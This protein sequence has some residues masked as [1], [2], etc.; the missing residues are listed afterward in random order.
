MQGTDLRKLISTPSGVL[1]AS[2]WYVLTCFIGGIIFGL[3]LW[4]NAESFFVFSAG[5][6]IYPILTIICGVVCI[7]T[8]SV[9][10]RLARE[11]YSRIYPL[12]S[13]GPEVTGN[14]T[15]KIFFVF[16]SIIPIMFLLLPFSYTDPISLALTITTLIVY[17]TLLK[18]TSKNTILLGQLVFG[19]MIFSFIMNEILYSIATG[20]ILLLW[21]AF[22][23]GWIIAFMVKSLGSSYKFPPKT[24]QDSFGINDAKFI[25]RMYENRN[26]Q[27]NCPAFSRDDLWDLLDRF[28]K[29]IS[30][31]SHF[32]TNR[33]VWLIHVFY[34]P[35]EVNLNL[36]TYMAKFKKEVKRLDGVYNFLTVLAALFP[37][38]LMFILPWRT[39]PDLNSPDDEAFEHASK[40]ILRAQRRARLELT[41]KG[42]IVGLTYQNGH[43][44]FSSD[45]GESY[46]FSLPEVFFEDIWDLEQIIERDERLETTGLIY[47]QG[48]FA[49]KLILISNLEE[50]YENR[51]KIVQLKVIGKLGEKNLVS[52]LQQ[53]ESSKLEFK[54]S[55]WRN[56]HNNLPIDSQTKKNPK[57]EDAIIKTI[58]G[59][60]NSEGGTLL[61]GVSDTKSP[62]GRSLVTGIEHDYVW[63]KKNNQNEDGFGQ[64]IENIVRD[65][66]TSSLTPL[67][68]HISKSFHTIQG[69]TICR[70]DVIPAPTKGHGYAV[71]AKISTEKDMR[72]FIRSG[73]TTTMQSPE[74]QMNYIFGHFLGEED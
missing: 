27:K 25:L 72:L 16:S 60:L 36:D 63:C 74:S 49:E 61:I 43:P 52:L 30:E 22:S 50:E 3:Q 2:K 32:R 35:I 71:F 40:L 24:T 4:E 64:A 21:A 11:E 9:Q 8:L 29:F 51:C 28:D 73:E 69:K 65:K 1:S 34:K 31:G 66:L 67:A 33:L 44:M 58:C 46:L 23:G 45:V 56:F 37:P 53:E 54:S 68:K 70:I 6:Y 7:L 42:D 62:D 15:I 13:F 10:T 57:L 18:I 17:V 55:L 39:I 41:E 19:L 5:D 47:Q 14:I 59:F 38:L 48:S 20:D 26:W 12:A